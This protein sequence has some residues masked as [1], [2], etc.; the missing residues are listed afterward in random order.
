MAE[1]L[2]YVFEVTW[3]PPGQE[4]CWVLVLVIAWGLRV[5]EHEMG[6]MKW[7]MGDAFC[8]FWTIT[9]YA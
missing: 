6:L 1:R 5:D 3:Q 4:K 9:G 7:L 2:W 8:G